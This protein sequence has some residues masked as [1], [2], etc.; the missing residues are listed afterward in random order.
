MKKYE[1]MLEQLTTH[2]E[3]KN[4]LLDDLYIL[5][6]CHT[7]QTIALNDETITREQYKQINYFTQEIIDFIV[8]I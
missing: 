2:F 8:K 7:I 4:S 5:G 6:I 1:N 3:K